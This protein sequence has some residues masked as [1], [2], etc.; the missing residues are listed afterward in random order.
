MEHCFVVWSTVNLWNSH[1]AYPLLILEAHTSNLGQ[2]LN[3]TDCLITKNPIFGNE[4]F[5]RLFEFIF[6][7]YLK[8]YI[9]SA[10]CNILKDLRNCDGRLL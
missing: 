2:H 4:D 1:S 6:Q 7:T 5:C 3:I 8:Y 9:F 10:R